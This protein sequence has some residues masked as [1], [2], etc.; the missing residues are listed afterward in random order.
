MRTIDMPP[1]GIKLR[2]KRVFAEQE[3][4][5]ITR[6]KKITSQPDATLAPSDIYV[7]S[8]TLSHVNQA[9]EV[10]A[11]FDDVHTRATVEG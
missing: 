4:T 8:P 5:R 10:Y 3:N 2:S 11:N 6:S 7:S 9:R 1:A